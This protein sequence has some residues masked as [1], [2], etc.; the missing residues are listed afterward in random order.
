MTAPVVRIGLLAFPQVTQLDLTGPF[1]VFAR[2]PNT[3]VYLVAKSL[4][5][6]YST[7]GN[8]RLQP[9]VTMQDAP[10]FK[11]LCVP[12]GSGV[13]AL[14]EDTETLEFLRR[15]AEGADYV[16]A[17]CTGAL[18]L[19]AAGLL[20]G[21]RATTHWLSLELLPLFGAI[22]TGGRVVIDRNRITGG[23]V[24]AGIDFGLVLA[25][26]LFGQETAEDVQL[27]MEYAPDPPFHSGS[28]EQAGSA[29]TEKLRKAA[30]ARQRER[31]EIAVRAALALN[32]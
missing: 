9:T 27:M 23:G 12:G 5:P 1:E 7:P 17:V 29:R 21:Y 28:P 6:V 31:R 19:G 25:A 26:Q 10:Q 22:P 18:V 8:L 11:V 16:T 13:A 2:L 20:R 32:S 14:M 30:A 24:T 4:D 3:E 15:Q